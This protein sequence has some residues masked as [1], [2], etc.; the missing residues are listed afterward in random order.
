M[1]RLRRT[2]LSIILI[3]AVLFSA[4]YIGVVAETNDNYF[5]LES[6][7]VDFVHILVNGK[8]IKTDDISL[9]KEIE[10]NGYSSY[11]KD[12]YED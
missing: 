10:K 12:Y 6:L 4:V 2:L 9:S 3:I 7:D 11:I 1:L 8:I 5:D